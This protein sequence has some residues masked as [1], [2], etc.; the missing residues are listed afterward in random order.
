[1][2]RKEWGEEGRKSWGKAWWGRIGGIGVREK[3]WREE[4]RGGVGGRHGPRST[5]HFICSQ[6]V[7]KDKC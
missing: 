5:R 3:E 7:N 6:E 4:C 2:V 1:M